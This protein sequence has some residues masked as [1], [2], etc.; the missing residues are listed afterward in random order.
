MAALLLRVSF[1]DFD[2]PQVRPLGWIRLSSGIDF[3]QL[4]GVARLGLLVVRTQLRYLMS[5]SLDLF[6]NST[7]MIA[8]LVCWSLGARARRFPG[9]H[10]QGQAGSGMRAATG[11]GNG[12]SVVHGS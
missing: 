5:D 9:F 8:A 4:L 11:S 12:R 2:P 1:P 10:L 3:C 7:A 6:K